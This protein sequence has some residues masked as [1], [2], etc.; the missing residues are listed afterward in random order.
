MAFCSLSVLGVQH[1][2]C[3]VQMPMAL[4]AFVPDKVVI[5][6]DGLAVNIHART[7]FT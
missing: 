4:Q 1:S 5:F 3:G 6:N 7:V 2:A